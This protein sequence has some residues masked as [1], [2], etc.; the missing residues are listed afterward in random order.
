MHIGKMLLVTKYYNLSSTSLSGIQSSFCIQLR[1][2]VKRCC[3]PR[4]T[5]SGELDLPRLF[6]GSPYC[7]TASSD[8]LSLLP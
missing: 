6:L 8:F 5:I 1:L 3:V 7:E 2:S 4:A